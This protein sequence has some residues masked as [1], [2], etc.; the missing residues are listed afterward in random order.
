MSELT[1]EEQE[2]QAR[3]RAEAR[4]ARKAAMAEGARALFEEV[5]PEVTEL[6]AAAL[7]KG[8]KAGMSKLIEASM[9]R[10][11]NQARKDKRDE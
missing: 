10:R 11:M 7:S 2:E 4:A 3:E 5:R 6:T 8:M 9:R 1:A